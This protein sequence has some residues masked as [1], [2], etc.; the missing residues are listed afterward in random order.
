MCM[1]LRIHVHDVT[2][3]CVMGTKIVGGSWRLLQTTAVT[4]LID[5]CDLTHLCVWRGLLVY[6]RIKLAKNSWL[7]F[8]TMVDDQ[9]DIIQFMCVT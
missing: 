1:R 4:L 8:E 3:S 9:S 2:H 6:S 5:M 7:E